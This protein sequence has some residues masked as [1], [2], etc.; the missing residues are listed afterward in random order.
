VT[1]P[2]SDAE[3]EAM[4][5]LWLEHPLKPAQIEERFAWKIDN[6][7]LRSTLAVLMEKGKVVRRKEG[8]A[9]LYSPVVERPSLLKGMAE[10]LSRILTGGSTA[11]LVMELV[12]SEKF[13]PE[14]IE[15]LKRIASAKGESPS[16]GSD[17]GKQS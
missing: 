6:G 3:L 7:T 11:D 10:R 17:G 15:E 14:Q 13:T 8:K 5:I 9:F 12:R 2:M 16:S 4:R 1:E